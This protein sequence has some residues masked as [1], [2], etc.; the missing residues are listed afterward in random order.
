MET[1]DLR[2]SESLQLDS[3]VGEALIDDVSAC[4]IEDGFF[5]GICLEEV[6]GFISISFREAFTYKMF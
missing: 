2:D 3:D 6:E 1:Q 5:G 4:Y